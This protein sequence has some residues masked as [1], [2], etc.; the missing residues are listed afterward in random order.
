[1]ALPPAHLPSTATIVR[2]QLRVVAGALRHEIRALAAALILLCLFAALGGLGR[3]PLVG[4]PSFLLFALPVAAVLPMAVWRGESLFGR[5]YLWTLPARRQGN[6]VARIFSGAVW[7][8]VAMSVTL[9]VIAVIAWA[10]GGHMGVTE[11]RLVSADVNP[12]EAAKVTWTTP[13]WEY[14]APFT[15]GLTVYGLSTAAIVGLR[16]PLRWV[17]GAALACGLLI[18]FLLQTLP[19]TPLTIGVETVREQLWFGPY[20]LDNALSGGNY[21]LAHQVE[22]PNGDTDFVWSSLPSLLPWLQSTAAWMAVTL[23]L[24]ALAVRRHA[25]R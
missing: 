12:S 19:G 15:A 2:Q 4:E 25:E 5:A 3:E 8:I 21:G 9:L 1:M 23:L 10:S 6:A 24:I 7:L 22:L 11:M 14:F 16:H 18:A 20:G 17:L 13:A